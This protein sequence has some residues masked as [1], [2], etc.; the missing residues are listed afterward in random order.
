M[1]VIKNLLL[2]LLL[3][4]TANYELQIFQCKTFLFSNINAV[5]RSWRLKL[6]LQAI[7]KIKCLDALQEFKVATMAVCVCVCVC[8]GKN[9]FIILAYNKALNKITT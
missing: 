7:E 1:N 4:K 5:E 9:V 3:G 6:C 8:W 2:L